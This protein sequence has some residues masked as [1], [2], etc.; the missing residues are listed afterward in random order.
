MKGTPESRRDIGAPAARYDARVRA[1]ILVGFMGAGKTSVGRALS[2]RLGWRFEDLDDRV[3]ARERRTVAEI[4]RESGEAEF[5][6]AEHFALRELL[7]EAETGPPLIAAL[8]GG[9]FV[10]AE[11]AS[12]LEGLATPTVFLDAPAE[13]LWRRCG[14]DVVERPLRRSPGEFRQLYEVRRPRYLDARLRVETGGREIE[15]IVSEIV[16]SLGLKG[17]VSGEER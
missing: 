11:N 16:D 12:L 13:E 10:E 4:F 1:V 8:G 7:A 14:A 15:R 9:A 2:G 6:R 17:G 5:R 3:Q